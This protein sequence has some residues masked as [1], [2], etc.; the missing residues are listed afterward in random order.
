MMKWI[1]LIVSLI[2]VSLSASTSIAGSQKK[3]TADQPVTWNRVWHDIK[4]DC[5]Q[6][7]KDV[8]SSGTAAGREVSEELKSLP[9]NFRK[10][11]EETKRDFKKLTGTNQSEA[12]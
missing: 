7:G 4:D 9:D 12:K 5:Q 11:M 3:E 8:K 2:V 1:T 6:I 10:G